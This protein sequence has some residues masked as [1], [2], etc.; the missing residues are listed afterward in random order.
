[1]GNISATRIY[2]KVQRYTKRGPVYQARLGSTDGPVVVN[3]S[4]EPLFAASRALIVLGITG[5]VEMWDGELPYPRMSG[6]VAKLARL[7]VREDDKTPP[8]LC[9]WKPFLAATGKQKVAKSDPGLL[10]YPSRRVATNVPDRA[11]ARGK[12]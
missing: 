5:R 10:E 6:D 4:L 12:L 2:I 11:V 9:R 3:S 1:M 7:T 8:T